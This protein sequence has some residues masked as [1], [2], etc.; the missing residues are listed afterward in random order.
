MFVIVPIAHEQHTGRR[1]P[2]VSIVIVAVCVL[3]FIGQLA[4]VETRTRA[5]EAVARAHQQAERHPWLAVKCNIPG[6]PASRTAKAPETFSAEDIDDQQRILDELC[7]SAERALAAVPEFRFGDIPAHPRLF[8]LVS[9]QFLHGGFLHIFFNMWFL[10]LASCNLED[11]WGRPLFLAFY[12]LSGIASALLHRA[13]NAGAPIPL[14]GASGAI[15]GAMGAFMVIL[16]TTQI[17]FGYII[18]LFFRFRA[19]TFDAPAYVMLPLWFAT[20]LLDAFVGSQDG[21]A[22]WAHVGG[23]AFGAAVGLVM[24]LSKL[25]QKLDAAI[26][27]K[28]SVLQ[29]PRI[30]EA[31]GLLDAGRVREGIAALQRLAFAEPRNIDVQL[32]LLRASDIAR[33]PDLRARATLELAH[34]YFESDMGPSATS[35]LT[36]LNQLDLY[37]RCPPA[38]LFA[39][40]DRLA[41]RGQ[42][43]SAIHLY[44]TFF[45]HGFKDD[46]SIRAALAYAA[47][48]VRGDQV[49]EAYRTLEAARRAPVSSPEL[50]S[51]VEARLSQLGQRLAHRSA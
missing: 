42:T 43:A 33:D 40:A 26:D 8:T 32:E 20:E 18:F 14:I 12:L 46:F 5:D 6:V 24:K 35:M 13:M 2:I 4:S 19:G 30:M 38:R 50:A 21:T 9:Y 11:R 17:R 15:A 45:R 31:S 51:T 22:H 49:E 37:D 41:Q 23:F 34:L 1:W 10:W 7:S 27:K 39:L 47:L 44:R 29:D 3:A 48:L 36:E 25:D 28:A 16:A